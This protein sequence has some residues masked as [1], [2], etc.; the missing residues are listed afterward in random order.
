MKS[1]LRW[2]ALNS[3]DRI[4]ISPKLRK[5]LFYSG[6]STKQFRL[7]QV[8]SLTINVL[9][10]C[11]ETALPNEQKIL[12]INNR[13]CALVREVLIYGNQ[14]LLMYG[15]SIFPQYFFVGKNKFF[16]SALT[17]RPLGDLLFKDPS[18]QRSAFEFA[19]LQYNRC[20]FTTLRPFLEN[21]DDSLWARRSI[22]ITNHQPLL[23]TEVFFPGILGV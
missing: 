16:R 13:S 17:N 5:W 12:Q 4:K 10:Q 7:H 14:Q 3:A 6:S 11:W 2:R 19:L 9:N 15:R 8:N 22:F 20:D 1:S 23:L 18:M 21:Q